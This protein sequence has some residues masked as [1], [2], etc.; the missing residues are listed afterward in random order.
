MNKAKSVTREFND[1]LNHSANT[2]PHEGIMGIMKSGDRYVGTS[3]KDD[4]LVVTIETE[5][6]NTFELTLKPIGWKRI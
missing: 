1:M 4:N 6:E 5:S 3:I 2:C